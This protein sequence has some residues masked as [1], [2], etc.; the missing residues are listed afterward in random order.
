MRNWTIGILSVFLAGWALQ[1]G[2]DSDPGPL[3][4]RI[5]VSVAAAPAGWSPPALR[6]GRRE[7][8]ESRSARPKLLIRRPAAD[9]YRV[10]LFYLLEGSGPGAVRLSGKRAAP[11]EPGGK[12]RRAVFSASFGPK[13]KNLEFSFDLTGSGR[14]YVRRVDVRNY[15]FRIGSVFLIKPAGGARTPPGAAWWLILAALLI[16]VG[17]AGVWRRRKRESLPDIIAGIYL[18]AGCLGLIGVLF[19]LGS[20][21]AIHVHPA[22]GGVLF[23]A[24]SAAAAFPPKRVGR[25]LIAGRLAIAAAA[26][27]A[28]LVIAEAALVLWDPPIAR[29]RVKSY[30]KYSPEF[31]WTN[32][33]NVRGWHVDIGYHIRINDFGHRGPDHTLEK[34]KGVFRILGLGDSFAF[35][36]GVEEG[37]TY[38]RVLEKKLRE[39][40]WRVEVINAGVPAWHS[41][42]MLEYLK[43]RG[44]RFKP[45]LAI[46]E[47]FV[48]DVYFEKLEKFFKS[49]IAVQ[50][51][52]EEEEVKPRRASSAWK[53]RLYH[54][55][56]NYRKIR[57]ASR[58]HLR[59]NPYPDFE[60]ERKTLHRDFDKY[61]AKV[62]GLEK[63]LSAW[64]RVRDKT[65]VPIIL[66]FMPP[67]G[68]IQSPPHQGEF[69]ALRRAAAAQGFPFLDVVKLFENH[70]A[71]RKLYLHP[72]DGHM[73]A[74]GHALVGDAL[75]RMMLKGGWLKK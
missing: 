15:L 53:P 12:W 54:L 2:A 19:H 44:L 43:K 42:Q 29:P 1:L 25:G 33:P 24:V 32:R 36:W 66:F 71:P 41:V 46:A 5:P 58:E 75:A 56:F 72:R 35:G 63:L 57:K 10:R 70:P 61:P 4:K 3:R 39:K 31:G 30:A 6:H 16:A 28:A 73:S 38:L 60:S 50:L 23:A 37:D 49:R 27:V 74:K 9:V 48:D 40:G 52:E 8:I 18:P 17:A 65:G 59:R 64:R 7:V 45:D 67:G 55:G 22:L 62:A 21:Y 34:P 51:R 26:T 13:G 14:L 69:R 47:F 11:L 20:G 68:A